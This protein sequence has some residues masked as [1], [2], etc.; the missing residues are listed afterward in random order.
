MGLYQ[1]VKDNGLFQLDSI[2]GLVYGLIFCIIYTYMYAIDSCLNDTITD[3]KTNALFGFIV[4]FHAGS[5]IVIVVRMIIKW[6]YD[7]ILQGDPSTIMSDID[8]FFNGMTKVCYPNG[9]WCMSNFI[10]FIA[11][12][13]YVIIWVGTGVVYIAMMIITPLIHEH[14]TNYE[15]NDYQCLLDACVVVMIEV[16]API[17]LCIIYAMSYCCYKACCVNCCKDET[18]DYPHFKSDS[19]T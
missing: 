2:P 18:A 6:H 11:I 9:C 7:N 12:I 10:A 1:K 3:S 17:I 4:A 16:Y 15:N 5:F 8:D 14:F 13:F 19:M